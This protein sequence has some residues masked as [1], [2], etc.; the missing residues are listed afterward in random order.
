MLDGREKFAALIIK[1]MRRDARAV[2]IALIY[3]ERLIPSNVDY[4]LPRLKAEVMKFYDEHRKDA[5]LFRN[6]VDVLL[7]N[8][9]HSRKTKTIQPEKKHKVKHPKVRQSTMSETD[10]SRVHTQRDIAQASWKYSFRRKQ[11]ETPW[12]HFQRFSVMKKSG[13]CQLHSFRCS[14]K[15]EELRKR[16]KP[17]VRF[18]KERVFI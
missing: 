11:R 17:N 15:A 14:F 10:S 8:V 18:N 9:A 5:L 3:Y 4:D 2:E 13:H 6:L 1:N 7:S 16:N 12:S